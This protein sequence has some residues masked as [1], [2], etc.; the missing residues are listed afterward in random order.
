MD[1][2]SHCCLIDGGPGP[3]VMSK[4]IMEDLGLY[5]TNENARSMLFYNSLQQTT[6]GKIKYVTL[7]LCAHPK[8]RT[9]LNIQVI[10]MPV[11]NYSII[12]GRYW[13]S[14]AGGYLSLNETHLFVP[15]NGKNIIFLREGR[16][17]PYIESVPQSIVNYIKEDQGVYSIFVEEDNI[18]LEQI[19]SDDDVW[20]MNFDG[21]LSNECNGAD[22]ILVSLVGKIHNLSYRS[23]FACIDN[24]TEFKDFL[25]GIE[26]TLNLGCGHLSIFGDSELVVNLIRKV[27]SPSNELMERYIQ[28]VW[29][30]ISNL[31]SFNITHVK[32][33][34]NSL[35]DKLF[36]FTASSNRQP[37]PHKHDFSFQSLY[38]SH[39][40]DNVEY[41]Q[42][43]PND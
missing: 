25:L 4:I 23:E 37:L 27:Y 5:C 42:A 33:E 12:L 29:A 14:L 30:L 8:I 6:I 10:Y 20:H 32:R 13:K 1:K 39:I 26:N 7:V 17:P 40:L 35:V 18:P 3:I 11:R 34:L 43:F 9:T 36:V 2:I 21:F 15:H 38:R 41:W 24:V 16:I 19:N 28:T 31:L 22:I